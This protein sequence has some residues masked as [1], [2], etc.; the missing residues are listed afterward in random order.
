[1]L[2]R[3]G[4]VIRI[5]S[6]ADGAPIS[7]L[8]GSSAFVYSLDFAPDGSTIAASSSD[9]VLRVWRSSGQL[10]Q[11]YDQEIAGQ[12]FGSLF[13]YSRDGQFFAVRRTDPVTLLLRNPFFEPQDLKA[14]FR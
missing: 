11:S 8:L 5:F 12:G 9:G 10:L 14:L 13:A 4:R 2:A 6:V 1:A 7:T 3:E